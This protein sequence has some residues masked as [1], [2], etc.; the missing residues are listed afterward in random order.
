[1][2]FEP[3]PLEVLD[4]M[5]FAQLVEYEDLL[6]AERG[7]LIDDGPAT[8]GDID[9]ANPPATPG[10]LAAALTQGREVQRRHLDLIDQVLLRAEA[11]GGQRILLNVGPRYGKTRR[12]R[13]ACLHRLM[14]RPETR[15]I[16]GSYGKSLADEQTRWVRD[17]IEAHDLGITVRQDTR[18]ADRWYIDGFEGGMLAA[19]VGSGITGFGAD[20]FVIDDVIADD[21]QAQSPTWREAGWRWYTQTAFDRLEPNASVVIVMT[22]WH[23]DDLAGRLLQQQ[24]GVWTHIRVPTVAED[25]DPIGRKP[26][27]LLWPERYDATAVA[28]QQRTLTAHG[29]AARHQQRPAATEGGLFK[30]GNLAKYWRTAGPSS[31]EVAGGRVEL[32]D[33]WRFLTVDLAASTRTS[34][35]YTV[36]A[37]WAITMSG[38]L[39]LLDGRRERI[40]PSQHATLVQDLR[41]AWSADTVFVESRMFGTTLVYELGRTGVPVSELKAEVDKYTRAMPAAARSESGLL[42][43]PDPERVPWVAGWVDEL[44]GFPNASHDDVVDVVAYAA[45]VVGT[46][47]VAQE[48]ALV[49]EERRAAGQDPAFVDLMNAAM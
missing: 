46:Q 4:R 26:G 25:D 8:T 13:W 39:V 32:R 11:E 17:Q 38:D 1:M 36:A 42:W 27:E 34:A 30:R 35:D 19:G 9:P 14:R 45:R 21:R 15:I 37:V 49:T 16:Y 28:E 41:R 6:L 2:A 48:S 22:R 3:L 31:I 20:L 43:L 44:V 23:A 10:E 7:E 40:D 29:F 5:S 12:V 47:W 24:P 18:R 33:C